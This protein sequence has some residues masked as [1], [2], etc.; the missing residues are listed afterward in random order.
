MYI[1][2]LCNIKDNKKIRGGGEGAIF[3]HK[4]L[5][6]YLKKKELNSF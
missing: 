5:S 4:T 1:N 2:V 3:E 6:S